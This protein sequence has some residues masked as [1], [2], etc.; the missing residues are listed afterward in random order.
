MVTQKWVAR[1]NGTKRP[2]LTFIYPGCDCGEEDEL[3]RR[4]RGNCHDLASSEVRKAA[5][6]EPAGKRAKSGP[7]GQ[8]S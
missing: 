6:Q 8:C 5:R 2:L 3:R 1:V 4:V 7:P